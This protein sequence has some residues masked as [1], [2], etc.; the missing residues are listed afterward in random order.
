MNRPARVART[1][2]GVREELTA[3]L[4]A[5]ELQDAGAFLR[6]LD[7]R[8][9]EALLD[10][11]LAAARDRSP[12]A[13][14]FAKHPEYAAHDGRPVERFLLTQAAVTALEGMAVLPV[15]EAV[16]Q[17][18]LEEVCLYS[19]PDP[20]RRPLLQWETPTFRAACEVVRLRRFPAGQY[21]WDVSGFSR[22]YLRHVSPRDLPRFLAFLAVGMRGLGPAF[23]PHVNGFRRNPFVWLETESNRS[24]YRMAK[25]LELQPAIIGLVTRAWL[26]DPQ[27]AE[28]SPHLAWV[29]R[30]FRENGGLVVANGSADADT[31]FLANNAA[32]QKSFEDGSYRPQYGVVLWP[33]R[34]MLSWAARHPEFAD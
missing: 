17:Q 15:V 10:S 18:L 19:T 28:T 20:K 6:R 1:I 27:L 7:A 4:R 3:S 14:L 9:V 12:I 13:Q 23:F 16:R 8:P 5:P 31:G 22:R 11:H 29:N 24:L 2:D 26:H 33:R 34:A 30:V 32:R 21:H 25:C